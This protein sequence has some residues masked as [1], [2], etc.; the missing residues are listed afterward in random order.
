M[1]PSVARSRPER[2]TGRP[3]GPPGATA[4]RAMAPDISPGGPDS[5]DTRVPYTDWLAIGQKRLI[6]FED[7]LA[8][9]RARKTSSSPVHSARY[10]KIEI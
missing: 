3:S 10:R 4:Y 9:L 5:V 8:D 2:S 1:T 7:S 6:V